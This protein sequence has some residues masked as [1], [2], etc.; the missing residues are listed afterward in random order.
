MFHAVCEIAE[1]LIA[2]QQVGN[3]KYLGWYITV[4][5]KQ[6]FLLDLRTLH[7]SMLCEL[8]NWNEEVKEARYHYCELN[9]YTTP[10]LLT[11]RKELGYLKCSPSTSEAISLQVYALLQSIGPVITMKT[12]LESVHSGEDKGKHTTFMTEHEQ[13]THKQPEVYVEKESDSA[14]IAKVNA[15]EHLTPAQKEIFD[16]IIAMYGNRSKE[17]IL[18]AFEN[19]EEDRVEIENLMQVE[20]DNY[21]SE[22]SEDNSSEYYSSEDETRPDAPLTQHGLQQPRVAMFSAIKNGTYILMHSITSK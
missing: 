18:K 6:E 3:I 4:P 1:V 15:L 9:Y 12:I 8:C 19:G 21:E 10:Q 7:N 14:E 13:Q 22:S 16:Y 5:C 11:L 17:V 20:I 2:L